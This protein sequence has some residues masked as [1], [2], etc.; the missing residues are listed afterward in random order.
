VT[1]E[2]PESAEEL[3]SLI[4]VSWFV[5][6]VPFVPLVSFVVITVIRNAA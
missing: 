5:P 1:G 2:A 4:I 3:F 6:F